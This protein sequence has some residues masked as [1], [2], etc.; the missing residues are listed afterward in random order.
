M[1]RTGHQSAIQAKL[2]FLE[3]C[4][5]IV[6]PAVA[7]ILEQCVRK[8]STFSILMA[9]LGIAIIWVMQRYDLLMKYTDRARIGVLKPGATR[10]AP[11]LVLDN[12]Y[13]R[14][15]FTVMAGFLFLAGVVTFLISV[16]GNRV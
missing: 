11:L 16:F 4:A 8:F 15:F 1:Q 10:V 2:V 3:G 9:M 14:Q 12:V 5:G 7:G 13:V 6:A